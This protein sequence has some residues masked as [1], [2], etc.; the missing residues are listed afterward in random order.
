M[1]WSDNIGRCTLKTLRPWYEPREAA[2]D[3]YAENFRVTSSLRLSRDGSEVVRGKRVSGGQSVF[4]F[5]LV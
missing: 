2:E 1:G 3:C 4:L 5:T